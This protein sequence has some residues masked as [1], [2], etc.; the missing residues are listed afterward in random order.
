M[1]KL[2]YQVYVGKK[3]RLYNYCTKL[4]LNIIGT[5]CI[6]PMNQNSETSFKIMN[7]LIYL[8]IR[9]LYVHLV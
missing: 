7:N 1:K 2:I 4:G 8:M 5:M 3:S 9:F 6:P